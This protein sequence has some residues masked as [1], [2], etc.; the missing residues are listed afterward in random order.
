MLGDALTSLFGA[1]T[2][3]LFPWTFVS[4]PP[5]AAAEKSV[6]AWRSIV[7]RW[8]GRLEY[9]LTTLISGP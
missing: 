3:S 1:L 7:S 2:R 6:A 9:A 8:I 5:L 4:V